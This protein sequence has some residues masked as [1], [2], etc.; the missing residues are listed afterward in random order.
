MSTLQVHI[1][2]GPQTGARLKLN[3]SP[4]SFGRSAENALIIDAPVVS[5]QHGELTLGD[6]G[7]WM[8]V[9]LSANGTRVGRKKATKKPVPLTDGASITIGD[10]E[11]FRVYLSEETAAQAPAALDEPAADDQ[12]QQHAPGA[13]LKGKSKLWIGIGL[14]VLFLVGISL[15]FATSDRG[16][17]KPT[18]TGGFYNPGSEITDK[19]GR[20]AGKQSILNRLKV[21]RQWQD[22]NDLLFNDHLSEARHEANAGKSRLYD[23]YIRYQKAI[24]YSNQQD[25]SN[26]VDSLP[27]TDD[28]LTY[29]R[30]LDELAEIIYDQYREAYLLYNAQDYARARDLLDDLRRDFYR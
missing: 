22:P 5:R 24:S 13:G 18:T 19:D 9:N 28:R 27:T 29:N 4:V 26:P 20:E 11:V 23:A 3:Q 16:G 14:W 17:E 15:F 8:L 6:D 12:A 10:T 1:L 7:R 2:A 21:A 30:V 25:K